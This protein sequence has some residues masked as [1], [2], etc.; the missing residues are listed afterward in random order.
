[1]KKTIL[2]TAMTLWLTV[3][4]AAAEPTLPANPNATVDVGTARLS[5]SDFDTLKDMVAGRYAPPA[6]T[7]AGP[8]ATLEVGTATLAAGDLDDLKAMVAGTYVAEAGQP[9]TSKEPEVDA[10]VIKM[11][12]SEFSR[13]KA[14]VDQHWQRDAHYATS[15]AEDPD[16]VR[17]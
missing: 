10:G 8:E 13:L 11:P 6:T 15:N 9:A 14:M 4:L 12:Q 3:G 1:M 2:L 17:R 7:T 5:Q 16:A